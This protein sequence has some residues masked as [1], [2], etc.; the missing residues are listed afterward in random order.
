MEFEVNLSK[1][2]NEQSN[3]ASLE[4]SVNSIKNSTSTSELSKPELRQYK[5]DIDELLNKLSKG[6]SK[7]NSWLTEY[8]SGMK[9]V[10][11]A[12]SNLTGQIVKTPKEFQ[13]EF[14]DLFG[15]KVM[16]S[17]KTGADDV[18]NVAERLRIESG[19]TESDSWFFEDPNYVNAMV[20][21]A[22]KYYGAAVHG[23]AH[24]DYVLSTDND[25]FIMVDTDYCRIMYFK[26]EDGAWKPVGGQNCSVGCRGIEGVQRAGQNREIGEW[27]SV[28]HAVRSFTFKGVYKIDHRHEPFNH[29][30][31]KG[32][33]CYVPCGDGC[34]RIH[35]MVDRPDPNDAILPTDETW[36]NN[37]DY[38]N[39]R[40]TSLGCVCVRDSTAEWDWNNIPVGTNV[41]IFDRWNLEPGI[42]GPGYDRDPGNTQ[43][44]PSIPQY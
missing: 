41:V 38:F 17:L 11:T 20:E 28:H 35:G 24:G 1:L 21:K 40:F 34:Q 42:T 15:K 16:G 29:N 30:G 39:S 44:M 12:L 25:W 33:I 10:E 37:V 4:K 26:N 9:E 5:S 2:E 8:I 3:F 43:N 22:N 19:L 6:Y 31:M 7:C 18:I 32:G 13:G 14:I 36:N 23:T 27:G